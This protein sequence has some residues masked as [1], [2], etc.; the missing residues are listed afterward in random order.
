VEDKIQAFLQTRCDPVVRFLGFKGGK[1]VATALGSVFGVALLI[2][3]LLL[4]AWSGGYLALLFWQRTNGIRPFPPSCSISST[5]RS[6]CC[7][8]CDQAQGEH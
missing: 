5:H 7:A 4:L 6:L 2:G 1:G 8:Y 3:L